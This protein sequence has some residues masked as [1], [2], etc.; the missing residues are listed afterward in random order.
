MIH[1]ILI[2]AALLLPFP[3]LAADAG[4][5]QNRPG[6]WV[7]LEQGARPAYVGIQG[8]TAPACVLRA[9]DGSIFVLTGN[10]GSDFS[11]LLTASGSGGHAGS[12]PEAAFLRA[13]AA[14]ELRP[15]GLSNPEE[16][17]LAAAPVPQREEHDGAAAFKPLRLSS[18]KNLL[19][20][21][22]AL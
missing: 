10:T 4:S 7:R 2:C 13:D 1:R 3:A 15:F 11:Q 18:Y 8:G 17:E 9:T 20:Y 14:V 6:G 12:P 21:S 5:A 19:N 22:G 16:T